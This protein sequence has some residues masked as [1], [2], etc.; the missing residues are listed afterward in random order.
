VAP[1]HERQEPWLRAGL[2]VSAVSIVWTIAT[3]GF[4][5][6]LGLERGS[7]VL[8]AFGATG[9]LD[10]VGSATLIVHFRHALRHEAFSVGHERVALRVVTAGLLVVGVA[11]LA[12]SARRL[13]VHAEARSVPAGIV[14]ATASAVMLARLSARKRTIGRAIPS[15]ALVADGWLSTAGAALALV[16]VGGTV[17][18]SAG[19]WWW[20]DPVAAAV[21]ATGAV[22]AGI[23]LGREH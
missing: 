21:V 6:A 19:S 5:I 8:V 12:E 22:T 11:T 23:V 16:T 9:L 18:T 7:L 20:A 1:A 17:L 4:A 2:R 14:I 13:A 10:A 15:R 3:S